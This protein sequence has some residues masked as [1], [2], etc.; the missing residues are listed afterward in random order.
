MQS[1]LTIQAFDYPKK[2]LGHELQAWVGEYGFPTMASRGGQ[3]HGVTESEQAAYQVRGLLVGLNAGVKAWCI[4]DMVNEGTNPTDNEDNMGLVRDIT[5]NHQPKPAFYSLQRVARLMGPDWQMAPEVQAK[6]DMTPAPDAA[7]KPS[8]VEGPQ[9]L[10]FRVGKD[11]VTFVWNAGKY[12]DESAPHVGSVTWSN[13]PDIASA[14]VQDLV[15]GQMVPA[16]LT[17]AGAVFT[18]A[19]VPVGSN[20][21]AIRWVAS[22]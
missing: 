21:V 18:L 4:Y 22:K 11:A 20:P 3:W 2:Y 5:H 14:Q 9:A 1:Y 12:V 8:L 16:M 6:L 17:H 15:T 13:A 10:W 7:A 19:G